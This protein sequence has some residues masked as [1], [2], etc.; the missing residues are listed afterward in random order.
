M[1][2]IA[3]IGWLGIIGAP[4]VWQGIGLVRGPEWPTLSDFFRAFMT[5]PAGGS[6]CSASGSGSVAS[7]HPRL[8]VL[9]AGL[10]AV[11]E[12]VLP[13]L[14]AAYV[15][16]VAMVVVAVYGRFR[17]RTAGTV[18][19]GCPDTR[20]P[21]SSGRWSAATS[22][23]SSSCWSSTC[24]SREKETCSGAQHGAAPFSPPLRWPSGRVCRLSDGESLDAGDSS[25]GPSEPGPCGGLDRAP[26]PRPARRGSS[27]SEANPQPGSRGQ[28]RLSTR[29]PRTAS[30]GPGITRGSARWPRGRALGRLA[31]PPSSTGR[32]CDSGPAGDA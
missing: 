7:V 6:S 29:R 17:A 3:I 23:S 9:P 5:T 28:S 15:A 16:F 30:H 8:V 12:V 22:R 32:A 21:A 19:S 20:R 26:A 24:G 14:V 4:L 27:P 10:T 2:A 31:P 25:F 11:L 18:D 1:R 13:P